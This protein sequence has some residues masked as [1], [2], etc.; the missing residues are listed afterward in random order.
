MD[1]DTESR[2]E[3]ELLAEKLASDPSTRKDFL[4]L[5]KKVRPDLAIP[6]VEMDDHLASVTKPLHDKIESLEGKLR[7]R[8]INERIESTR[9]K[10]VED[11]I[12]SREEVPEIEKLMIEKKIPDHRTAAEFFKLQREQ[13][14]P[15]PSLYRK[16]EPV[17]DFK[18]IGSNPAQWARNEAAKALADLASGR[19]H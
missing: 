9:R 15:T 7:E 19:T 16:S 3:L 1:N 6:E 8:D 5:A 13:A 4:K 18:T 11:G 12:V 2:S 17:V 14:K 10:L